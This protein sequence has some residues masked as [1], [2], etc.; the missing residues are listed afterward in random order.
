MDP[1]RN[2][3]PPGNQKGN[4]QH[5]PGKYDIDSRNHRR[6]GIPGMKQAKNYGAYTNGYQGSPVKVDPFGAETFH[7]VYD[8]VAAEDELLIE[9]DNNHGDEVAEYPHEIGNGG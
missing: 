8:L 1:H 2:T 7:Q 4:S 6:I 5:Y 9:T 3:K